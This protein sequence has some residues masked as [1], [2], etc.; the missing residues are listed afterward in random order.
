MY[1][2]ASLVAGLAP[3][4]PAVASIASTVARR[5]RRRRSPPL[6]VARRRRR[7]HLSLSHA[8]LRHRTAPRADFCSAADGTNVVAAFEDAIHAAHEYAN[9]DHEDFA[10]QVLALLNETSS[11]HVGGDEDAPAAD[12]AAANAEPVP[13]S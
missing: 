11:M 2:A 6:A 1:S 10:D 3:T 4:D 8:T 9:S 5:R 12:A 13:A 7:R